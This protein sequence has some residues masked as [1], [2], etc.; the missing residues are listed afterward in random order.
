M[1]ALVTISGYNVSATIDEIVKTNA[2]LSLR[3]GRSRIQF[4]GTTERIRVAL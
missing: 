1:R 3:E 2:A 4:H